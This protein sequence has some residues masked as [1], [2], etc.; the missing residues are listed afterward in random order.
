MP[1]QPP[2]QPGP[3]F[4]PGQSP[5]QPMQPGPLPYQAPPFGQQPNAGNTGSAVGAVFLGF[6]ASVVIS[7]IY[8]VITLATAKDQTNTTSNI[9]YLLH[10]LLNGVVVGALAGLVGRRSNGARIGAAIIAALGTFFGYTNFV[11]LIFVEG[12]SLM[13]LK[14]MLENDPLYPAMTWGT[15][16]GG[17]IDWISLLGLPLAAAAAWGLAYAIGNRDRRA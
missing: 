4:V 3:P 5:M 12:G 2:M 10:A 13:S 8:S 7:L 17:G 11:A 1:G 14:Y 15:L 16:Y 9:F 6:F